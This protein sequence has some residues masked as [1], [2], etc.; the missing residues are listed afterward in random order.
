MHFAVEWRN[1][2]TGVAF[3]KNE[4]SQHLYV[5]N[6]VVHVV[7]STGDGCNK[8]GEFSFLREERSSKIHSIHAINH[9][10]SIYQYKNGYFACTVDCEKSWL[11]LQTSV[12]QK[13][14][15]KFPGDSLLASF[16]LWLIYFA[17]A[18]RCTER[19]N[20]SNHSAVKWC[21]EFE[22]WTHTTSKLRSA[23]NKVECGVQFIWIFSGWELRASIDSQ[24]ISHPNGSLVVWICTMQP[25]DIWFAL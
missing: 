11:R 9:S 5:R 20:N 1:R 23:C 4:W 10:Q 2:E 7:V 21:V 8:N 25:W 6:C 24:M 22:H 15:T 16:E 3:V 14:K 13:K 17:A 18:I 12:Q 19:A